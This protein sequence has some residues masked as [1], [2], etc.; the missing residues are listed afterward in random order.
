MGFSAHS[1]AWINL[2]CA[3]A[4]NYN[5]PP[6]ACQHRQVLTEIDIG[7]HFHDHIDPTAIGQGK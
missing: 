7:Q 3:T 4:A 6:T 5:H 2:Y 1:V